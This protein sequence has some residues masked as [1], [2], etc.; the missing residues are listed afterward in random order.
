MGNA[1]CKCQE[2]SKVMTRIGEVGIVIGDT[3]VWTNSVEVAQQMRDEERRKTWKRQKGIQ[4]ED[5]REWSEIMREGI[6]REIDRREELGG[7]E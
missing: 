4:G 3:K 2:T 7:S 5:Q 1:K 6:K